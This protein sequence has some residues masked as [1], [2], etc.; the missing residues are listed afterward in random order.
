M[1]AMTASVFGASVRPNQAAAI[2]TAIRSRNAGKWLSRPYWVSC[3]LATT[4]SLQAKPASTIEARIIAA[5]RGASRATDRSS[6]AMATAITQTN[7]VTPI[8]VPS[9]GMRLRGLRN[10]TTVARSCLGR[11]PGCNAVSVA[12]RVSPHIA[13]TASA[14][15]TQRESASTPPRPAMVGIKSRPPR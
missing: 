9:S 11:P 1:M 4:S 7:T 5:F 14:Y 3:P 13:D 2:P 10:S 15:F 12:T 8:A 6:A